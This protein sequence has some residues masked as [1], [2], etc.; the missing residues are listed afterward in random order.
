MT[1]KKENLTP[2]Q[3]EAVVE[4]FTEEY[5]HEFVGCPSW[6]YCEKE[7]DMWIENNVTQNDLDYM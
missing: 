2:E 4:W 1:I 5:L 3:F 7:F 6:E